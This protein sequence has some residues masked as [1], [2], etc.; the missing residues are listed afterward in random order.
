M[1]LYYIDKLK[2]TNTEPKELVDINV[3]TDYTKLKYLVH[4]NN[5]LNGNFDTL[6]DLIAGQKIT[7]ANLVQDFSALDLSKENNF[8]SLLFSIIFLGSEWAENIKSNFFDSAV[9]NVPKIESTT[10]SKK[11]SLS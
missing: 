3:R 8:K 5:K 10:K 2:L 7:L 9:F 1:I 4:T 11:T 6:K